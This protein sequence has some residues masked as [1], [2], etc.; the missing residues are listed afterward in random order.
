[1]TGVP[2]RSLGRRCSVDRAPVQVTS[3]VGRGRAR[4]SS[5]VE[6]HGAAADRL[7]QPLGPLQGAVDAG[8]V[9]AGRGGRTRG[10]PGHGAGADD[11]HPTAGQVAALGGEQLVR[12]G[13]QRAAGRAD[14]GLGLDPLADPDGLL[15]QGVEDGADG[16]LGLAQRSARPCTWPRIW[17]SPTTTESSPAATEKV[18]ATAPSSK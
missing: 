2:A 11:Q 1:M 16:A 10:Q 7:G 3:D 12:R 14:A 17:L 9:R 5:S 15:E 18:C 4:S 6:R 8:D 13:D